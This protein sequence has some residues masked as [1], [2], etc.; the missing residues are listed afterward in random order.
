MQSL[1]LGGLSPCQGQLLQVGQH[2]GIQPAR[3]HA[4]LE[5]LDP[6]TRDQCRL[7]VGIGPAQVIQGHP[8]ALRWLT[9]E[10]NGLGGLAEEQVMDIQQS[11]KFAH[12]V[13]MVVHPKVHCDVAAPAVPGS[14][15]G[16]QKCCALPAPAVA[17]REIPRRQ[18]GKESTAKGQVC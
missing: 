18:R 3:D 8:K 6:G 15:A 5:V 13:G 11:R 10:V 17:S 12:G 16:D 2:D 7:Q 1:S 14:G 9:A 4:F